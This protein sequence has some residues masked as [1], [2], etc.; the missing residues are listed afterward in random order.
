MGGSVCSAVPCST[1]LTRDVL[2]GRCRQFHRN[3]EQGSSDVDQWIAYCAF[4]NGDYKRAAQVS[5]S[6][7]AHGGRRA[8]HDCT[9]L[10]QCR[11]CRCR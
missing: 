6:P 9:A 10:A 8:V 11:Y 5:L 3:S 4:H 1:A 2:S 7:A